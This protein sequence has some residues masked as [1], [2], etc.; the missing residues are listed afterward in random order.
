M[1]VIQHIS[2]LPY[3]NWSGIYAVFCFYVIS[4]YL[5]TLI[6][7]N[8]YGFELKGL[9]KFI[10]N[11][12]LRIYPSYLIILFFSALTAFFIPDIAQNVRGIRLPSS[13]LEWLTNINILSFILYPPRNRLIPITWSLAIELFFY[14]MI[15]IFFA[16]KK[17]ITIFWFIISL[18]YTVFLIIN[19]NP[20][21]DR[22]YPIYTASLPFSIG[23]M[24]YFIKKKL[25]YMPKSHIFPVFALFILNI[26]FADKIWKNVLLE[27]F[28]VSLLLGSY[29]IICLTNLEKKDVPLWGSKIDTFFGDL[30]YP[31]FLSHFFI[32]V[33]VSWIFFSGIIIKGD[34]I[35]LLTFIFVNIFSYILNIL[36]ITKINDFRDYIKRSR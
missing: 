18:T 24:I 25:Q 30:S 36:F 22:Y 27:G 19:A 14:L 5:M 4:G 9:V 21:E 16:R 13:N 3:S 33:L 31:I 35:F 28:Y 1:V 34:N 2:T 15:G 26:I 17:K 8:V 12:A 29:L 20:W 6:L 7:N 23:A 32:A 11:R 10:I